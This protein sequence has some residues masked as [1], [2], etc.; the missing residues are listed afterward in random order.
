MFRVS[1]LPVVLVLVIVD[2]AVSAVSSLLLLLV[3]I[4]EESDMFCRSY[5]SKSRSVPSYC[6]RL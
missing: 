6:D 2:A 3:L 1:F 4:S 5:K